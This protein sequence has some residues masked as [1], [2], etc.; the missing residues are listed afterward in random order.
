MSI[1][2]GF[3]PWIVYWVLVGNVPFETAVLVALAVAV[4]SFVI[5][6]MKGTPGRTLEVGA[7]A[8]F[9]V[10]AILTF[11]V[12]QTFMEQWMQPLS[13]AGIFLVALGSLLAGRPFVREFAEVDQPEEV[14]E[15]DT[16]KR[17][18]TLLTWIWIAAFGG[19][20]V[21]SMI[22][23]I[24]Y[25]EATI[26]DT[27]TPLSFVC[28]WVIPFTLL[29]L[30]A[31]ASRVLPERMAPGDDEV[32]KTSFVTF[33]EAEIDQL[34]YAATEAVK[35]EVGPNKEPYD[36]RIGSKGVPL[37]SDETRESWPATYKVRPKKK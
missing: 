1:L 36:I 24:V 25:G 5:G 21:S 11:T 2:V 32:R 35:R 6:R 16:F 19:M 15:S 13:N 34:M 7:M 23:P 20:T 17:I 37:S 22:P 10:L 8:V 14:I 18:T 26:L 30:A 33:A 28:Y 3:A 4:A 12:S 31:L 9:V 27:R 29:G